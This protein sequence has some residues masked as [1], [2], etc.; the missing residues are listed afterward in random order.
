MDAFSLIFDAATKAAVNTLRIR[1]KY[2]AIDADLF[3]QVA[4][5]LYLNAGERFISEWDTAC[6]AIVSD[7]TLRQYVNAQALDLGE[8]VADAYHEE[9][10]WAS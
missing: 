8:M 5:P 3:A 1:N 6:K 2:A 10:V 7:E 9:M 4:L